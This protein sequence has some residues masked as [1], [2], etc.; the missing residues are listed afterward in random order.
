MTE[1]ERMKA[2]KFYC[3]PAMLFLEKDENSRDH[4][5][6]GKALGKYMKAKN[7][8]KARKYL[9]AALGK[10]GEGSSIASPFVCDFPECITLGDRSY[11]NF[12]G[13][14]LVPGGLEIGSRVLIAPN[15]SIYT[16]IHPVDAQC[17]MEMAGMLGRKVVIEDNVWVC[18]SVTICPGVTIGKGSV[19]GAGSVVTRDIPAGVF[20]A[21][22]PCRVIR[23]LGEA[24]HTY[25]KGIMDEYYADPDTLGKE[26]MKGW[27]K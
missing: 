24:E 6:R 16:L 9:Q 13:T 22:N 19:I 8:R 12:G 26:M 1:Y 21:G 27:K 7:P 15:V 25:W 4:L 14:F 23:E 10:L 17:R 2:G 20:A 3:Q 18:G 11:V 5:R